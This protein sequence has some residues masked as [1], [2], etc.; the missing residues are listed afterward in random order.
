M[1][2]PLLFGVPVLVPGVRV[3]KTKHQISEAFLDDMVNLDE[4]KD[5][6]GQRAQL[7]EAFRCKVSFGDSWLD[8]EASMFVSRLNGQSE[9]VRP[10][11]QEL[12]TVSAEAPGSNPVKDGPVILSPLVELVSARAGEDV[13]FNI[14]IHNG[15]ADSLPTAGRNAARLVASV[16]PVRE[17]GLVS[18]LRNLTNWKV[19]G[20]GSVATT[21]LLITLSPGR[22]IT[23]PVRLTMLSDCEA[24]DYSIELVMDG[25]CLA[26]STG[27]IALVGDSDPLDPGWG[28]SETIRDYNADH[29][30][31]FEVMTG[32]LNTYARGEDSVI[33]ELG[34]NF[35][36]M[37]H[38]WP[39]RRFNM[40]IDAHGMFAHSLLRA[41]DVVHPDYFMD[42]IGDGMH[43]PFRTGSLDA[44]VMYATFHH[45]PDPVALLRSFRQKLTKG[46]IVML[47]CEPV[48]HVFSE[49]NATEYVQELERGA[50]EQS[51]MYWEYARFAEAAGYEVIDTPNDHGSAKIVMRLIV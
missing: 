2:Y 20:P 11:Y 29:L 21:D 31:A 6:A 8:N 51:F 18:F 3:I 7:A 50:F 24:V 49:H 19:Q 4:I 45:F 42:V 26:R 15:N 22:S 1:Y 23:Q 13:S 36:P 34:G 32:W 5:G 41:K 17:R 10:P 12:D 30:H 46:G 16:S 38:N 48:G 9:R 27:R 33:V 40:D 39:G 43:P 28:Q 47:L 35:S 37:L 14:K 25:R 44:M